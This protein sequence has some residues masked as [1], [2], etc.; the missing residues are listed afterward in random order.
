MAPTVLALHGITSNGHAWD[1]VARELGGDVRLL[2]PDLRGRGDA[3]AEPGPYGLARH[4]DDAIARL[5]AEELDDAVVAGHSMGAYVTALLAATHPDRV[6]SV[7]LVDGGP[8]LPVPDGADADELLEATLGPSI[9]RLSREFE[10]RAAYHE[11]WHAH[12]AFAGYDVS[13]EDLIAY[14]DHDLRGEPPRMRSSVAEEAVRT[15]GR[16]L[17]ADR[18]V[19][20]AL[21]RMRTP[22]VLLRAQRGLLDQPEAF[23]PAE[24]AAAFD[25][26]TVELHEVPDSN[27]F[28]ILMGAGGARPVADA[29][30]AAAL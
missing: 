28:T 2:A 22:G 6:R 12:P 3:G 30:R 9:E 4:V 20:T 23:I 16:E 29:I 17:I 1:A 7:V 8:P 15:D 11:F 25:H 26:P 27:H 18:D 19:R 13:E 21:E 14:A 10:S 5:D 24:L